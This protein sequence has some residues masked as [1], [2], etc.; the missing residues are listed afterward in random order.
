MHSSMPLD[1]LEMKLLSAR[2][3]LGQC[4][5]H[6]IY[7]I[8]DKL[9]TEGDDDP[10]VMNVLIEGEKAYLEE[11]LPHF[12]AYLANN[13]VDIPDRDYAQIMVCYVYAKRMEAGQLSVDDAGWLMFKDALMRAGYTS[14]Y[15]L[16]FVYDLN[17]YG[18]SE[19]DEQAKREFA[20]TAHRLVED[21][22]A[23]QLSSWIQAKDYS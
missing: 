13:G 18:G 10:N 6:E 11:I 1:E 5:R 20:I 21:F 3:A 15:D 4:D 16:D 17:M 22:E 12:I 23:G 7:T 14:A 8:A 2:I 9:A 19:Y